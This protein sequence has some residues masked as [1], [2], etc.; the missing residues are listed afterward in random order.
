MQEEQNAAD[1][2]HQENRSEMYINKFY[3]SS[4]FKFNLISFYNYVR[5]LRILQNDMFAESKKNKNEKEMIVQVLKID[6]RRDFDMP[7]EMEKYIYENDLEHFLSV[8]VLS[9]PNLCCVDS[10]TFFY[11]FLYYEEHK[12]SFSF[13]QKLGKRHTINNFSLSHMSMGR[14]LEYYKNELEKK[15]ETNKN[16][17]ELLNALT[18]G[19]LNTISIAIF[20]YFCLPLLPHVTSLSLSYTP[21][22]N[23]FWMDYENLIKINEKN[24]KNSVKNCILEKIRNFQLLENPFDR[25][26]TISI[27]SCA[28]LTDSKTLLTLKNLKKV[29]YSR[30]TYEHFAEVVK[31][32]LEERGVCVCL[33]N[34]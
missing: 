29:E 11:L 32:L 8:M 33:L 4:T 31:P 7:Y 25:L 18:E 19:E 22:I 10:K 5:V 14:I 1:T 28:H 12:I 23:F 26:E 27:Q 3:D 34:N 15:S 6:F 24:E 9:L 17:L 13:L 16:Y 2:T 20:L 21:V 30:K